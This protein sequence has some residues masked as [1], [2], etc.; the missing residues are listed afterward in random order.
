MT[1][2]R[3]RPRLLAL[4]LVPLLALA[5]AGCTGGDEPSPPGPSTP[6][7]DAGTDCLAPGPESDSVEVSGPVGSTP[8]IT[9]P[10]PLSAAES[11]RTVVVPGSGDET[12]TGDVVRVAITVFDA[13]TGALVNSAGYESGTGE[14]LTISADYYVPGLEAALLCAQPGG[15]TVTVASAA[16]MQPSQQGTAPPNAAAV[17][18]VDTFSVVPTRATGVRQE[19][20]PGFPAV[21][22]AD[23]GR[24]TVTIPDADPPA[25]LQLEVLAVGDGPVVPDPAN[26]TVQYQGVNWRTGEVFDESWGTGTPAT[27][28]T[29]QVVSGFAKAL[30]GQTVGSQVLVVVP[31][32]EGYGDAG[33]ASAGIQPGDTLD[34]VVDVLAVA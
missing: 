2:L 23:D 26:V 34:F 15:R 10:Q 24:P 25:E 32:S 22:L 17:I 1:S 4:A 9:L 31:P 7:A 5:V 28:S 16:D 3:R 20:Q 13:T 11:Q 6:G 12:A 33:Q 18:V 19:A 30:V 27:F 21:E 14:Q 8:S 29:Q